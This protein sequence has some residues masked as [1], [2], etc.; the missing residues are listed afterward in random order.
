M[1]WRIAS[2]VFLIAPGAALAGAPSARPIAPPDIVEIE[3]T[4]LPEITTT[5]IA[6][7]HLVRP[8]GT[9]SLGMFGSVNVVDRQPARARE[10]IQG[11]LG[12]ILKREKNFHV[13][14]NVRPY[15]DDMFFLILKGKTGEE[16]TR[17]RL[18]DAETVS[19]AVLQSNRTAAAKKGRVWLS[20]LGQNLKVDW[21]AITEG[22][23][24]TNHRVQ[25]GDRIYISL[26]ENQ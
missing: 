14:I 1:G 16:A 24:E 21:E 26:P 15:G 2:L 8:D 20:R 13:R 5:H 6:G 11:H 3:V 9:I 23:L 25:A 10:A 19:D 22:R 12:G 7:E 17:F 4:G 18:Q